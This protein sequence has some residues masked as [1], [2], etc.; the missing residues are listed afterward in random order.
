MKKMS[1]FGLFLCMLLILLSGCSDDKASGGGTK[2]KITKGG[3]LRVGIPSEPSNL[4]THLNTASIASIIGRNIFETLLTLDSK[5]AVQPMLAESYEVSADGKTIE[6]KLRKG[7]KFHNGQEMK[8]E[9]VVASMNRW[10]QLSASG[11]ETF[12][13]A[14]FKEIDEYTVQLEMAQPTSTATL[15][16]GYTGAIS[17]SIMPA[18][19]I[20][21]HETEKVDEYIGTGPFKFKE[22]KQNQHILL[23]KFDDYASRE[24]PED[25][26]AGKKEALVDDLYLVFVPD[27]STR[28]AG[29]LS[30]EYDAVMEIPIDNADQISSNKEINM[31]SVPKEI[32]LLY[33]NKKEGLF[34]NKTAR[35]AMSV[36]LNKKDVLKAAFVNPDYYKTTHHVMLGNQEAQWNTKVGKKE[37]SFQDKELAKKLFKEAGYNGEELRLLTSRDLDPMYNAAIVVQEQLKNIG[38]NVKLEVYDWPTYTE[39]GNDPSAYDITIISN[40]GKPEPTSLAWGR[41]DY[42]GW[43]NSEELNKITT[44]MR[45][46]PTLDDA[47]AMYDDLQTWFMDYKP[48]IKFGDGDMLFASRK[49][50]SK[51]EDIDG[52]YFWNVAN[53]K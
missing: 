35:D 14:S 51:L 32:L 9:D 2:E 19:V 17:P 37:Y 4:D 11:K 47:K 5:G 50:V 21:G 31:H 13:G 38:V 15:V 40:K 10:I 18:S 22:W 23:T 49:S 53:S 7:V 29:I 36:A 20:K 16:L 46:A 33:F 1:K 52:L 3:E 34:T 30:G 44:K 8:A 42:Y 41:S 45:Q 26:L 43:T 28:V 27:S 6:F 48:A 24:E 25:G 12:K 39:M